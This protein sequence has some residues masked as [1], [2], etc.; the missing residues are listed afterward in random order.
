[1]LL[2]I[3]IVNWNSA[4]YLR[5]CLGSVYATITGLP[6][7][8]IVVDNASP[9]SCEEEITAEFPDIRF[10]QC[11]SN[12]GFARANNVG[13]SC[14]QGD[15]LLFL[16]PDTELI[17]CAVAKMV[18]DLEAFE[19]GGA[20]GCRLLNSDHTIQTSAIHRFPTIANQLFSSEFLRLKFPRLDFWGIRPLFEEYAHPVVVEAISGACMLVKREAFEA[21]GRF[22]EEFFMYAEDIDLCYMIRQKG[23]QVLYTGRASIVHHGGKSSSTANLKQGSLFHMKEA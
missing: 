11:R 23:Y 5:A 16:N 3:I 1:M 8:V 2:S 19:A 6:F 4:D 12:L 13:F 7:E 15:F 9:V 20:M 21:A 18:M 14:A 22:N 17:G 10:I